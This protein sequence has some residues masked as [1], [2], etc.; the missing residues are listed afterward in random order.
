M[1]RS[2]L[3]LLTSNKLV[4]GNGVLLALCG[5]VLYG[6]SVADVS[7]WNGIAAGFAVLSAVC[8]GIGLVVLDHQPRSLAG[9]GLG[10][11]LAA[12]LT[13]VLAPITTSDA[14][15]VVAAG[16]WVVVSIPVFGDVA[17]LNGSDEH[18]E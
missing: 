2:R 7:A 12:G 18:G 10:A 17:G 6:L 5:L 11:L 15:V 13:A 4:V 8:Y 14:L 1:P 9:G 3:E 16:V